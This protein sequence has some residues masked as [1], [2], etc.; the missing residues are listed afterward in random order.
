MRTQAHKGCKE[1]TVHV[2]G[3]CLALVLNISRHLEEYLIPDA[4]L[5]Y[6]EVENIL[7]FLTILR[8]LEILSVIGTL[9]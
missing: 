7:K 4:K 2:Q 1:I 8:W 6:L 5:K 9:Y 3:Q